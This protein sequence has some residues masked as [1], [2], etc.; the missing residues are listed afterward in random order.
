MSNGAIDIKT[1]KGL[2][3]DSRAVKHGYLFAALP[4]NKFDGR[5]Y[6][7]DAVR[8]GA[9][10]ILAPAGTKKPLGDVAFITDENPRRA[11]ALMAA[12][13]YGKQP[14]RIAAVTGTNGKTSTVH[15]TKQ[16]W[17]LHGLKAAS[18]GTLGVRGPGM[19]RSGSMTT[20]D[21]VALHA[22]LADLAAAGITHLAMEA[23]S[24]GLH[25]YRLDGVR[26]A[27][28]GFTNFT[29]D[30]LDYHGDMESYFASKERLFSEILDK[31]GTAVLNA[32]V[33]EF[34]ALK[35]LADKK[36]CRVLSFGF[37]AKDMKILEAAPE[38]QGQKLKLDV[39][40]KIYQIMLPVVGGFQ[41]M[42]ALCALGLV[43]SEC[44]ENQK[45]VYEYTNFLS[46]LQGPPGRLQLV[47]GHPKNA[48]IYIDYAHTP[49]ALETVL[50]ALRPHTS[51]KLVCLFGCGGDRDRGKRPIMG[52][53]AADFAD[54][55]I[56]TDDNPRSEDPASIRKQIL[57]A[58]KGAQEI[59]DRHE[60]IATA[61]EN[62]KQGDVLVIAGKGH[63]QGQIFANRTD[64]FDDA[65]EAAKVIKGMKK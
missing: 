32:D 25:Q 3:Q 10:A 22:E 4:G 60:A 35:K 8:N 53:I 15:F 38:P 24:H 18:I 42:N 9:S 39:Q 40:G 31:G 43:I 16:L 65:G 27:A 58:A 34:E 55:V 23:S 52:K 21:P 45:L 36:G 2:T 61:I 28:A 44:L 11:L 14:G 30:H 13:F 47:P 46:Q 41:V 56:V 37:K 7:E 57:E 12:T 63:E 26:I 5:D 59:G 17:A 33:P 19:V 64:P 51:G 1:L 49:D 54:T 20:P 62:L 6:I 48:A 29:R 50:K